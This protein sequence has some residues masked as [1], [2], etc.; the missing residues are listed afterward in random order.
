M[1]ERVVASPVVSRRGF[2]RAVGVGAAAA[3]APGCAAPELTPAPEP[4]VPDIE[5]GHDHEAMEEAHQLWSDM[6]TQIYQLMSPVGYDERAKQL[7]PSARKTREQ[8]GEVARMP[9]DYIIDNGTSE[10][11]QLRITV[12]Y[13]EVI[14][15]NREESAVWVRVDCG[16]GL[17]TAGSAWL[18]GEWRITAHNPFHR[19]VD[20]EAD[21]VFV[22]ELIRDMQPVLQ[23]AGRADG[24]QMAVMRTSDAFGL[25][26]AP[27]D[28][29]MATGGVFDEPTTRLVAQARAV[30]AGAAGEIGDRVGI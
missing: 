12:D 16:V 8:G 9:L 5:E 17:E 11:L 4:K 23:R 29:V 30:A 10:P 25:R 28:E 14:P 24:Q 22:V 21:G 3:L 2:L 15:G 6:K 27:N 20:G 1:K 13:R 19:I 18:A 7:F 26:V